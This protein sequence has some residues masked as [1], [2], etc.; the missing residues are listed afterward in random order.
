[1]RD[2]DE[3][4]VCCCCGTEFLVRSMYQVTASGLMMCKHCY[5]FNHEESDYEGP[6]EED[7]W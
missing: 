3:L 5:F 7:E 6:C 2:G 4:T 1:M